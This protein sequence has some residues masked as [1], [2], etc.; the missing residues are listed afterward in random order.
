MKCDLKLVKSEHCTSSKPKNTL[1]QPTAHTSYKTTSYESSYLEKEK[2]V[3][4]ESTNVLLVSNYSENTPFS[5]SFNTRNR[6]KFLTN[7]MMAAL[8]QPS[9]APPSCG[10]AQST[11]DPG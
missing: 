5:N 7:Q 1:I 10:S 8:G 4:S 2:D 3:N 6:P 11:V 9:T